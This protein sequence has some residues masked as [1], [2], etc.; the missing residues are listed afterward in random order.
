MHSSG[1]LVLQDKAGLQHHL[2]LLAPLV[3]THSQGA[4]CAILELQAKLAAVTGHAVEGMAPG[5]G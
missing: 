5:H 3:D 4:H 2:P 1:C